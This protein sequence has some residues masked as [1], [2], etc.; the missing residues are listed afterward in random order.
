MTAD[1][2]VV[3]DSAEDALLVPNQ[4]IEANRAA[5]RYYVTRQLADGTTERLEVVIGLRD[6]TNTQ[7]L[8]GLEEGDIVVLPEVPEQRQMEEQFGPGQGGGMPFGGGM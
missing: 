2:D 3:T 1:V 4:A 8:E 5:G 7:I 6:E